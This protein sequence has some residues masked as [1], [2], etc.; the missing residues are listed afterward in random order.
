MQRWL[1]SLMVDLCK[2]NPFV[3]T[4]M[5]LPESPDVGST[6]SDRCFSCNPFAVWLRKSLG[7]LPP[8]VSVGSPVVVPPTVGFEH[9]QSEDV[10]NVFWVPP[11]TRDL[12]PALNNVTVT[13]FN[14]AA[15]GTPALIAVICVGNGIAVSFKVT[16]LQT[17]RVVA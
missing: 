13:A 10:V 6:G 11:R 5:C 9:P 15:S 14:L 2:S 3:Q 4:Q 7:T 1:G 16:R 17:Q 8:F 12:H